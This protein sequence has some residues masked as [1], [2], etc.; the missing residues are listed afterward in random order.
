MNTIPRNEHPNPQFERKSFVNLNGEWDFEIDGGNSGEERGL[1][2][3]ETLSGK[4]I[5]PFCPES[6]L[7]GIANTDFLNRVWYKKRITLTEEELS[8][9]VILTVGAC[10][11]KTK[12]WVN[13][14]FCT[15]HIGGFTP[16][17]VAIGAKLKAGENVITISAEDDIRP[18][19]Q[20]G[21]KQSPRFGSFGCFYTRTTGIWQT[22][23]LEFVP[24]AYI[25]SVKYDSLPTGDVTIT[26]ETEGAHGMTFSA[27][28]LF[29]GKAVAKGECTVCGKVAKMAVKIENPKLW[30]TENP[31]LYDVVLT[32]GDDKVYSYFGIRTIAYNDHRMY[33]NGKSIFGR[34][35]LDQ[36]YYPDG[37]YTAPTDEALKNDILM[38]QSCGY[39]G[40][41]LHQKIFEPRFLYHCDKLGYMVWDEHAN[42]GL[43]ISGA[44]GWRG[45]IGEWC[46]IMKRD[47]NHP[48]IIGWCPFNET[49][50]NQDNELIKTVYKLT[51][52][53]DPSRL[54]IDC[55][56]WFHVDGTC[57]MVDCHL[58]E[59]DVEKFTRLIRLRDEPDFVGHMMTEDLCFVS[60]FGGAH[61]DE[62]NENRAESWGYG[63]APKTV[64]DFIDRYDG[65]VTSLLANDRICAF[66]Y[67]QLTD[68]HQEKNG[69]FYFDRRPKFDCQKLKAITAKKSVC[70]D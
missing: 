67:T 31:N 55:S 22:V 6:E 16:I 59:Q 30:D 19:K 52:L 36:G 51:K 47:Y 56:G 35:I 34:F 28:I 39:N 33:L 66:C 68:V 27:D 60:E 17:T 14:V 58:Y 4:I 41:R 15:E 70:E 9:E 7:S 29:D 13:G 49:Q 25:T 37:V 12:I 1:I 46:E 42:W 57:D 2:E 50:R 65:L 23:M 24:K 21:G 69:L 62:N 10:D 48:S 32:L 38:S 43:D 61:W 26:A 40:A 64:D 53:N 18:G 20:P 11:Y 63:N 5:V 45:F 44:D 54:F 8:G 3:K